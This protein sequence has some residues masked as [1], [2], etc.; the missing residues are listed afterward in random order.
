VSTLIGGAEL[1]LDGVL[2]FPTQKIV[3]TGGAASSILVGNR[4][5]IAN[6]LETAGNGMIYL[7]G[8]GDVAS[9]NLGARLKS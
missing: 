3:V 7:R 8:N 1:D 9:V 6:R 5:L 4:I 2:Y